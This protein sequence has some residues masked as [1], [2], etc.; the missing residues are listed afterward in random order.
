MSKVDQPKQISNSNLYLKQQ[1]YLLFYI[2]N[3]KLMFVNNAHH[4]SSNLL[5][6][7]LEFDLRI[8][9]DPVLLLPIAQ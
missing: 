7:L 5:S 3:L 4:F 9:P 1:K 8:F 6:S 2:F